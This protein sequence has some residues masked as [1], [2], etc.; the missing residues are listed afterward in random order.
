METLNLLFVPI[1]RT[2]SSM[3]APQQTWRFPVNRRTVQG[4][5]AGKCF[6]MLYPMRCSIAKELYW[7]KGLREYRADRFALDLFCQLA[8]TADVVLDIGANTGLF[9]MAAAAS[10]PDTKIHAYEIVPDV[11]VHLVSNLV[12]NEMLSQ[13]EVHSYGIGSSDTTMRVPSQA[14]AP[15]LPSAFSSRIEFS[16]GARVMFQTL[17][18][19]SYFAEGASN[20]LLK[21]DVEGT[22]N[23][24]LR[25]GNAFLARF[26]PDIIC[27]LLPDECK[28]EDVDSHLRANQY[29]CYKILADRLQF[30][31]VLKPDPAY[32]DWLFTPLE[33]GELAKRIS[34]LQVF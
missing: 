10:N 24:I 19:Q 31:P 33:V 13:V 12:E 2:L 30:E 18:Q 7:N 9:A 17:D 4:V 15:A 34:P 6:R 32:H 16:D 11:V 26:S 14:H 28:V 5:A 23:E 1:W 20:V 22:E 3:T 29:K 25:H 8:R 21:I 27:E